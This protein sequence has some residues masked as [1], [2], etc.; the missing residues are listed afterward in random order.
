M[1]SLAHAVLSVFPFQ[2]RHLKAAFWVIAV[3]LGLLQTW[4]T[5]HYMNP[6]GVS[7]LD[8]ADAYWRGD[9][10]MAI[11]GYWSPFYSW[12]L[13]L[14]LAI[15]SPTSYWEATVVHF[16]NFG[17]YLGALIC[18]EFFWRSLSDCQCNQGTESRTGDCVALPSWAWWAIG[19]SL[20]IWASLNLISVREV[21]PDMAV[22]AFV[23]LAAGLILRINCGS[24]SWRT[25]A[26]LGIVLGF[27]YLTK[28]AM[29]P[30]AFVFLGAS[31]VANRNWRRTG[32]LVLLALL[33]FLA[34]SAPFVSALTERKGRLTFGD[35]GKLNYAWF[36]NGVT[37][38]VHW[39]GNDDGSGAPVHPTRKLHDMP[40]IYEFVTPIGGTYP[41][42][43]DPAYWYEG[44]K[45]DFDLGKQVGV[46]ASN[47]SVYFDLFAR[48]RADLLV[49][50]IVLYLLG[51]RRL[52]TVQERALPWML[53]TPALAAFGRDIVKCCGRGVHRRR[54]S[55]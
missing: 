28:A 11:N 12:I 36:V 23:Y 45:L 17:V 44:V 6:D 46:L 15:S 16:T 42:W 19:Y 40:A 35:S 9:W 20:F 34:V 32:P 4:A 47:A 55:L 2:D 13:G 25:F 53:L 37:W 38:H 39:Q 31:L 27:G 48:E 18:F 49:G 1:K 33:L 21:T 43:Y 10:G 52:S 8:V 51:R 22:A 30:L 5:R 41:P 50:T 3:S 54:V 29:F 14:P 24:A 7:Y 26:L